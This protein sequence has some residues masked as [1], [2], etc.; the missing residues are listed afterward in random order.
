MAAYAV[1]RGRSVC[2]RV[3]VHGGT[4]EPIG[5]RGVIACCYFSARGE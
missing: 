2:Y 4:I 3:R 1:L 5:H